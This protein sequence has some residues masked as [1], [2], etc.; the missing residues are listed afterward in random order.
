M[1]TI[2]ILSLV[3]FALVIA[4]VPVGAWRGGL[5]EGVL[6]G[7]L[8]VTGALIISP[9]VEWL[10]DAAGSR[11]DY[12]RLA[13]SIACLGVGLAI[14]LGVGRVV[15]RHA[16]SSR[17][18]LLGAICALA[19]GLWVATFLL[20]AVERNSER[21]GF[22]N[23]LSDG[24]LLWPLATHAEIT[25]LTLSSIVLLLSGLWIVH[26]VWD[27]LGADPLPGVSVR[28]RTIHLPIGADTGKLEPVGP[29]TSLRL[30][31]TVALGRNRGRTVPAKRQTP[32]ESWHSIRPMPGPGP[33]PEDVAH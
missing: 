8:V 2:S 7:G 24:E 33:S 6:G 23:S 10:K 21:T 11:S 29:R 28:R 13:V 4:Y 20:G 26:L 18:R 1:A 25:L 19:N 15:E 12:G 31:N 22:G 5:S 3:L 27:R 30:T 32:S 16:T 9:P 14:G 17:G